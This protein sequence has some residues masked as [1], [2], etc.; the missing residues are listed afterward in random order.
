VKIFPASLGRDVERFWRDV[1]AGNQA[2]VNNLS[3]FSMM[4][5]V[6]NVA[7]RKVSFRFGRFLSA[8]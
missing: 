2:H 5:E 4:L 7:I 8:I 3:I 1:Q 6:A